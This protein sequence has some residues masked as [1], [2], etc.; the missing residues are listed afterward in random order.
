MF[1]VDNEQAF[2]SISFPLFASSNQALNN[3]NGSIGFSYLNITGSNISSG[4][5]SF[6]ISKNQNY[7]LVLGNVKENINSG[8]IL[9][10]VKP[11]IKQFLP[12]KSLK[13]NGKSLKKINSTLWEFE[14]EKRLYEKNSDFGEKFIQL[15]R[16]VY[17]NNDKRAKIKSDINKLLGSN[18]KEVK[19]Y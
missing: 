18:I 7:A 12:G 19:S 10:S 8:R 9:T 5:L 2:T 3:S 13:R 1:K 4:T 17:L 14:D 15:S 11:L 16:N 6:G